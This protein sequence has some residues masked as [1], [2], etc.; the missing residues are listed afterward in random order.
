M[1]NP[2]V[3]SGFFFSYIVLCWPILLNY[4]EPLQQLCIN[5]KVC[6]LNNY[7]IA[8][9]GICIFLSLLFLVLKAYKT[10]LIFV[11][12]P[13]FIELVVVCSAGFV[14]VFHR[15][16][17]AAIAVGKLKTAGAAVADLVMKPIYWAGNIFHR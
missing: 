1:K 13:L 17:T 16:L 11:L 3:F 5:Q 14:V 12:I 15:E 9:V 2:H 6:M 4:Y 7:L 8:F 10:A